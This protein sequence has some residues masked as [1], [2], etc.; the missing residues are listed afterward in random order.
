[1]EKKYEAIVI[2]GGPAGVTAGIYLIRER[3]KTVILEKML[4]GGTPLNTQRIENYPGFPEPLSGKELMDRFLAQAKNYGLEIREFQE[5]KKVKKDGNVFSIETEDETYET[6]SIIVAT[7]TNPIKLGIPGEE[8]YIGRGVSY[9]ATC[10]GP[11]F[12]DRVVAVIGGG[13][14]AFEEALSLANLAS[15][16]YVVHRRDTF[17]AQKILQ[18]RAS[19]SGKIEFLLNKKPVEIKGDEYVKELVIEDTK[20]AQKVSVKVDGIFVYAGSRPD[21]SFLGD[22]VDRDDSG[23]IITDDNLSTKTEGVFAAGDVRKK[24]LRQISTAVGDG[25]IAAFG[26]QRYLLEKKIYLR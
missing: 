8:E 2:G 11:F 3:I 7:G 4:P 22:L 6:Y 12:R 23:F 20:I 13:D 19:E 9:C 18:E 24:P 10:D 14:S 26:V 25:A 1:M 21:T 15:R 16:V 17:R 5:V